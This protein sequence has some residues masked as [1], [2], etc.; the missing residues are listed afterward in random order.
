MAPNYTPNVEPKQVLSVS[1]F[2]VALHLSM[3]IVGAQYSSEEYCN[4]EA[5]MYLMVAGGIL[6]TLETLVI[7]ASLTPCT[8]DDIMV[9]C[10]IPL[11][12]LTMFAVNIWGSVVVFG[13]YSEWVYGEDD[14][15]K[16]NFCE[17]TPFMFAFVVLILQWVLIP[18][19]ICAGLSGK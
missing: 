6:F 16:E 3:L 8:A 18:L 19:G 10:L 14:K 11:V 9:F 1:I 12:A 5:P 2:G 13:P 17:Y 7:L 15:S 4:L